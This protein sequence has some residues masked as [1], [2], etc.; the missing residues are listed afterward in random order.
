MINKTNIFR[1][2]ADMANKFHIFVGALLFVFSTLINAAPTIS[3][4]ESV[5]K[6]HAG[7]TFTVDIIMSDFPT[8]EGGGVT[9]KFNPEKLQVTNVT[10]DNSIW[11]FVN[12]DGDISRGTVSDILFSSFQGV[13]GNAKI[14]SI[15]FQSIKKGRSRIR[16]EESESNPFASNG[17][18]IDVDFI[19]TKIRVRR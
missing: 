16:L 9:L 3:F 10:V 6:S 17:V 8:T 11:Q 14:A 7:E 15:Q 4:S 2:K 5:V 12:N 1:G 13:T 19:P 18:A